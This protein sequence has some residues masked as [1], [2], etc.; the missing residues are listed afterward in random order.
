M[1]TIIDDETQ[2]AESFFI[3][4][5]G[6][7]RAVGS[8]NPG[9]QALA[10]RTKFLRA[11]LL[12]LIALNFTPPIAMGSTMQRG[13]YAGRSFPVWVMVNPSVSN[14]VKLIAPN[15]TL[16]VSIPI[17]PSAGEPLD[18]AADESD[19]YNIVVPTASSGGVALFSAS[20]SVWS[21]VGIEG[22][23]QFDNACVTYDRVTGL[24][25]VV[26]RRTSGT[27]VKAWTSPDRTSWTQ[28]TLPAAFLGALPSAIPLSATGD[29]TTIIANVAASGTVDVAY[30]TDG[31]IT[32]GSTSF[33]TFA[34]ATIV[35]PAHGNGVFMILAYNPVTYRTQVW[36]SATG[37]AWTKVQEYATR[38]RMTCLANVGKLWVSA[39]ILA[40]GGLAFGAAVLY[41]ID[42]GVTWR[43]G[44][45]SGA[46]Q[47]IIGGPG[48]VVLLDAAT[49]RP[50]L[51]LGPAPALAVV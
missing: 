6:N 19:P 29:G 5:D 48:A 33:A 51:L 1:S 38:V 31:G 18:V 13:C 28:R 4:D 35:R 36:T 41:S 45:Y 25:C 9:F 40:F 12:P 26:Y 49:A 21:Y 23:F 32:W 39:G 3:P 42:N 50:S 20:T 37:A 17:T 34:G 22:G 27:L 11:A 2:F 16:A 46:V 43:P 44:G 47:N 15:G 14:D 8:V 30:S 7:G 24:W 10:N